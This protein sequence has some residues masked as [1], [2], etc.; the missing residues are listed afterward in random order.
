MF[1]AV[2][3]FILKSDVSFNTLQGYDIRTKEGWE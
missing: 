1:A 3:F 2:R